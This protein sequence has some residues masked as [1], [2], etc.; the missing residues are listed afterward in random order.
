MQQ[1]QQLGPAKA[2]KDLQQHNHSFEVTVVGLQY[3]EAVADLLKSSS[4][5]IL[6]REPENEH[7]ENA[8]AVFL[9][10]GEDGSGQDD[11][12]G[13][14]A[15]VWYVERKQ[16]YRLA[17]LLDEPEDDTMAYNTETCAFASC[18]RVVDVQVLRAGLEEGNGDY[19]VDEKKH[20]DSHAA[21][22]T[23]PKALKLLVKVY[24]SDRR[25]DVLHALQQGFPSSLMV[26]QDVH[27]AQETRRAQEEERVARAQQTWNLQA[28]ENVMSSSSL[29]S[30]SPLSLRVLSLFDGIGAAV[31]ALQKEGIRIAVYCSSEVD[32][33]ALAVTDAQ[34][35]TGDGSGD[36]DSMH[37]F[38]FLIW[39]MC[40]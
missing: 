38:P 27:D 16:A 32:P 17:E 28:L 19:E 2:A 29:A 6:L 37:A 13:P 30:A 5:F 7:D 15:K 9:V 35:G 22:S 25:R 31:V 36:A 8:I 18:I 40:A 12:A 14:R 26:A 39:A 1:E 20:Y 21:T 4:R 10:P 3:H 34:F 23:I 24:V 11:E 33:D